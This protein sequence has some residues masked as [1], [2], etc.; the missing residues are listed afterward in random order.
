MG[1]EIGLVIL[2]DRFG[3]RHGGP[4]RQFMTNVRRSGV[5]LT[6]WLGFDIVAA[7]VT[8]WMGTWIEKLARRRPQLASV[9]V[10]AKRHGA[11]VGDT[12]DINGVDTI[13]ALRAYAPEVVLVMN[14]DQILRQ[15]LIEGAAC[16]IINIHPSLLPSLRGPCPVFWALMEGRP[17][18]GVSLHLIQDDQ[19]DAGAVLIQSARLLD[20]S[21]SVAE[22]TAALFEEGAALFLE[23]LR[24]PRGRRGANRPQGSAQASYRGF[25][26]RATLAQSRRQGVRLCRLRPLAVLIAKAVGFVR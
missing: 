10:L 19:V 4:L 17:E 22:L 3:S 14:F 1:N 15:E 20:R 6:L 8:G 18:V 16:P 11:I 7:Q 25:P 9:R 5:R 2:S 24:A 12:A 21:L 13:A 26:D 23:A